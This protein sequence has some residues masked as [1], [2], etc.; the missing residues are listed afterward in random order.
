MTSR[1]VVLVSF[2]ASSFRRRTPDLDLFGFADSRRRYDRRVRP[3]DLGERPLI[4]T[5]VRES[6]HVPQ[7]SDPLFCRRV[8]AGEGGEPAARRE[9][10]IHDVHRRRRLVRRFEGKPRRRDLLEGRR[11]PFGIP[12][13]L[14]GGC[15]GEVF[16]FS[17]DRKIDEPREDRGEDRERNGHD[18]EDELELGRPAARVA[19]PVTAPDPK[20]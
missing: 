17:R 13:E 11:E 16:S 1:A 7:D 5:V 4:R 8:R 19:L 12:G 6:G 20:G 18:Y 9:K 10:R 14:S 2:S 3:L 15:V